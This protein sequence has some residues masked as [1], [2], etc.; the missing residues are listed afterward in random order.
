MNVRFDNVTKKFGSHTALNG[1]SFT[2]NGPKI[3]G[4]LGRNGAGKTTALNMMA[5]CIFPNDGSIEVN[6]ASPFS[7]P[8]NVC[9]IN[10]SG[11]F[12]KDFTIKETLKSAYLFYPN[13]DQKRAEE[14]IE[15]FQLK[16]SKK[17]KS[18]SKGMESALGITVGLACYSPL[19]IFDE[20][21]IGLDAAARSRFYDLLIEEYERQPRLFILSTHLIDEVAKLFEDVF[22]IHEG[23]L[24]LHQ[25]A[26][27]LRSISF[28]ITGTK[29]D[30]TEYLSGKAPLH[31]KE[32]AGRT[33]AYVYGSE[34]NRQE[35]ELYRLET[36]SIPIQEL[37]VHL[38][39][40]HTEGEK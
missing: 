18:L 15:L 3:V 29:K 19:T 37:M 36:D 16:K 2:M 33:T 40:S 9:L 10:E 25:D 31:R 39:D 24:L 38:T 27:T 17:I 34:W 28:S 32:F 35:A 26:E 7:Q 20:P 21:Y 30:V 22:I 23:S 14:L 4:L 5:G 11:N 12:K 13:W 1:L 6:G 8:N